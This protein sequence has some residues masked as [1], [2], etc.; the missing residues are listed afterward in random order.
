MKTSLKWGVLTLPV[1]TVVPGEAV[2]VTICKTDLKNKG[3]CCE[4]S[5]A[6]RKPVVWKPTVWVPYFLS[7]IYQVQQVD[8]VWNVQKSPSR[9]GHLRVSQLRTVMNSYIYHCCTT[10]VCDFRQIRCFHCSAA[11]L[12]TRSSMSD[13]GEDRCLRSGNRGYALNGEGL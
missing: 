10:L 1:V 9:S 13:C 11:P 6:P 3:Y 5:W 8:A 2:S 12:W 4:T 7:G